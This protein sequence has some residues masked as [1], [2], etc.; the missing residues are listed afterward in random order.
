MALTPIHSITMNEAIATVPR[1]H[2]EIKPTA[3]DET[4]F[5]AKVDKNGP[6]Q[7][8]MTTPCWIWMARKS[9]A[10]YGVLWIGAKDMK[11]HRVAYILNSG[12]IDQGLCVCHKCD[13]PACVNPSHLFLGTHA[14][15]MADRE[16]K[17]RNNPLRGDNHHARL[18]PERLAR[19][20]KNGSRLHPECLVRGEAVSISKL[21]TS[22]VIDLRARYAAGGISQRRLAAL[23]GVQQSTIGQIL[24]HETW[25]H[26]P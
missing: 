10:G 11:A 14:E 20:D 22:K 2:T 5:W 7:S 17:G 6:T 15:N 12:H 18:H 23:Y 9:N 24:R 19:G 1:A 25:A 21:T 4:R 16:A 13:I 3:A 26:V 8:H